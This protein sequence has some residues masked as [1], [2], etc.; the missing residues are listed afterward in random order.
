MML[1]VGSLGAFIAP[2]IWGTANAVAREVV[3]YRERQ[4]K[5]YYQKKRNLLLFYVIGLI[6]APFIYDISKTQ[7]VNVGNDVI[8]NELLYDN[9]F[10]LLSICSILII[11]ISLQLNAS[12]KILIGIFLIKT[13]LFSIAIFQFYIKL[14]TSLFQSTSDRSLNIIMTCI[15]LKICLNLQCIRSQLPSN[16]KPIFI[17]AFLTFILCYLTPGN[18]FSPLLRSIGEIAIISLFEQEFTI[19]GCANFLVYLGISFDSQ[20]LNDIPNLIRQSLEKVKTLMGFILIGEIIP[21]LNWVIILRLIRSAI[22]GWIAYLIYLIEPERCEYFVIGMWA[23]MAIELFYFYQKYSIQFGEG[24]MNIGEGIKLKFFLL[25]LM[26]DVKIFLNINDQIGNVSKSFDDVI[27][28]F[29]T[30]NVNLNQIP[31]QN[32]SNE[33]NNN[34]NN[35][36]DINN[37]NNNNGGGYR[38]ESPGRRNQTN[39]TKEEKLNRLYHTIKKNKQINEEK[40]KLHTKKKN[41]KENKEK[42][43]EKDEELAK[44]NEKKNK[45]NKK[46]EKMEKQNQIL[47]VII[48]IL[49]FFFF[50][51]SCLI[52]YLFYLINK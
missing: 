49:I 10:L 22:V 24:E 6:I 4:L 50:V 20:S 2:L 14:Q 12:G 21:D 36:R 17:N 8:V 19:T 13:I 1:A 32:L 33:N 29:S 48:I 39:E 15:L 43:K 44:L 25:F 26:T 51:M 34:N 18:K 37:N 5:L 31:N 35:N 7:K 41:G 9:F 52:F 38:Y 47:V 45:K 11:F 28:S 40:E 30:S 46:M 16:I 3:S 42:E 23:L 27:H